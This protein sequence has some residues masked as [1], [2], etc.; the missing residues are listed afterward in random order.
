MEAAHSMGAEPSSSAGCGFGAAL[1]QEESKA[2]HPVLSTRLGRPISHKFLSLHMPW[3]GGGA[4]QVSFC[5]LPQSGGFGGLLCTFLLEEFR[6]MLSRSSS[7]ASAP[8]AK[9]N[10]KLT[11]GSPVLLCAV[12]MCLTLLKA[13]SGQWQ[14]IF[15]RQKPKGS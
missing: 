11:A 10:W 5:C 1:L 14:R 2:R 12:T 13:L 4:E 6:A 3:W 9:T 8:P 15:S 7:T